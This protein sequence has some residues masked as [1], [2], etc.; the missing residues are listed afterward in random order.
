[1]RHTFINEK[2]HSLEEN[3]KGET[4]PPYLILMNAYNKRSK[5][6]TIAKAPLSLPQRFLINKRTSPLFIWG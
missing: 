5:K 6:T 2:D 4:N 1:M 3:K